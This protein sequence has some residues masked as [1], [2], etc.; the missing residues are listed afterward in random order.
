MTT[1]SSLAE[2]D[3]QQ[4]KQA[5]VEED[6]ILT[7]IFSVNNKLT[8]CSRKK[9]AL[10]RVKKSGYPVF[11]L[12]KPGIT[13]QSYVYGPYEAL[14][15]LF[16]KCSKKHKAE[17]TELDLEPYKREYKDAWG[18]Y[19]ISTGE[20][21]VAKVPCFKLPLRGLNM[22][23]TVVAKQ[24]HDK[25]TGN[26][27]GDE[28]LKVDPLFGRR[29][30][31]SQALSPLRFSEITDGDYPIK[32][33][34]DIEAD[35]HMNEDLDFVRSC[36]AIAMRFSR[37]AEK[38]IVSDSGPV[39]IDSLKDFTYLVATRA[40]KYSAH[41][42]LHK[43]LFMKRLS[44]LRRLLYQFSLYCAASEIRE[45]KEQVSPSNGASS[46]GTRKKLE[47]AMA[48]T[49]SKPTTLSAPSNNNNRHISI[50]PG[51]GSG[52]KRVSIFAA[53]PASICMDSSSGPIN[54]PIYRPM[55]DTQVFQSSQPTLRTYMS[56]KGKYKDDENGRFRE[57]IFL[58][59][60]GSYEVKPHVFELDTMKRSLLQYFSP[61]ERSSSQLLE[62]DP[63]DV[64]DWSVVISD[65]QAQAIHYTSTILSFA[66]RLENVCGKIPECLHTL[67]RGKSSISERLVSSLFEDG[68][69]V[70]LANKRQLGP[71]S[72]NGAGG[73]AARVA[74]FGSSSANGK[75][76]MLPMESSHID[77]YLDA[78]MGMFYE[79]YEK[80]EDMVM[81]EPPRITNVKCS[82]ERNILTVGVK[83]AKC[84]IA[85]RN[86]SRAHSEKYPTSVFFV[87]DL[88]KGVFYQ[89][90]RKQR[91][92]ES[93]HNRGEERHIPDD[94]YWKMRAALGI[95]DESNNN[96][97][98]WTGREVTGRR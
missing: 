38:F 69:I 18:I 19:T 70:L 90:C 64:C 47:N 60:N 29:F 75:D 65:Y 96:T 97:Q 54:I 40:S 7:H 86:E 26:N 23:G 14:F 72:G 62:C 5:Y 66:K 32:F 98:S 33:A 44:D 92:A 11:G 53:H 16:E 10:D 84:E 81:E 21:T 91:C 57:L 56:N 36:L 67:V 79:A 50:F 77:V 87:I 88:R 76:V 46:V 74:K 43:K 22:L 82:R 39:I 24:D 63:N 27:K 48:N 12:D 71:V 25:K 13:G 94:I 45:L 73:S 35:V 51:A 89:K 28:T 1:S 58:D 8:E 52:G 3:T 78:L 55:I 59:E 68:E 6:D 17:A 93:T 30:S 31:A 49:M 2:D 37:F 80:C 61:E 85:H 20:N 4:Q 41:I 15:D 95:D 42:I 83:G 34:M 9:T